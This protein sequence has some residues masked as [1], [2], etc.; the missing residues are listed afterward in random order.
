MSAVE[1]I[2]LGFE[3]S[4][5]SGQKL[6]SVSNVPSDATVGELVEALLSQMKLPQND[7]SGRP[8]TYHA[9]LEREGRHLH[10]AEK[11]TDAVQAGD[12][13]VLQP[14]IDAGLGAKQ[15]VVSSEL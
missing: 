15:R 5:V 11:V 7:P 9:L 6:H 4:D 14:N 2:D 10:A 8:L 12:R 13:V 3:V 1:T